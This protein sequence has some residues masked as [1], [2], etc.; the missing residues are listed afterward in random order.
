[1]SDLVADKIKANAPRIAS[2][3]MSRKLKRMKDVVFISDNRH[4]EKEYLQ[5]TVEQILEYYPDNFTARLEG[6][7]TNLANRSEYPGDE[8]VV[9]KLEQA[10]LFY[11]DEIR[12]EAML[13]MINALADY[14]WVKTSAYTSD[15]ISTGL[16]VTAK[17]WQHLDTL[18]REDNSNETALICAPVFAPEDSYWA[19]VRKACRITGYS[20]TPA[21]SVQDAAPI[22][23]MLIAQ[24][25]QSRVV[26]CEL[27]GR[28]PEAYYTAGMAKA[29]GKRVILACKDKKKNRLPIDCEQ[30][31]VL[32]WDSEEGFLQKLIYAIQA[33]I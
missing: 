6:A 18:C 24:I 9:S 31:S 30:I 5:L 12:F 15:G 20:M 17:G 22:S 11:V 19:A 13:F 29:L 33:M 3:L 25:K 10:P 8:I 32:F 26:V 27:S 28:H 21:A 14:G 7:L 2:Y 4:E 23:P 1:M 16:T